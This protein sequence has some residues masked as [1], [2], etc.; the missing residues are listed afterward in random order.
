MHRIFLFVQKEFL[1]R[2]QFLSLESELKSL[3]HSWFIDTAT[4][5]YQH[6]SIY[7]I[8]PENG[9]NPR[10][11]YERV[12]FLFFYYTT[13]FW[14]FQN[15]SCTKCYGMTNVLYMLMNS[16]GVELTESIKRKRKVQTKFYNY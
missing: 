10:R 8:I 3:F 14:V 5:I 11:L 13:D 2:D 6:G 7:D 16:K 15:I 9:V 1:K 12:L 4:R